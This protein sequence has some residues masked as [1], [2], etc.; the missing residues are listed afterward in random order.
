[1]AAAGPSRRVEL[2][3]GVGV[4][5]AGAVL[6]YAMLLA[7]GIGVRDELMLAAPDAARPGETLA[8]RAYLYHDPENPEGP[9]PEEGDVDVELRDRARVLSRATLTSGALM[10]LEGSIAVPED[11][12]GALYLVARARDDGH[13]VATVARPLEVADD[14]APAGE[15]DRAA[16]PLAHFSLGT[17]TQE[18]VPAALATAVEMGLLVPLP[19][20]VDTLDAWV[21]GGVCVPDARCLLAVDVGV[22]DV[23][24]QLTNCAGVEVLPPLPV[25]GVAT[26]YHVLPLVVHG[27]EGTCDIAAV[28]V[29]EGSRGT[30]VAHRSIRFPVAL[31]TPFFGVE[32]AMVDGSPR[33][34]AIAP[35]GRDGIVLDVFHDGRWRNTMTLPAANEPSAALDYHE[36]PGD[37]LPAGVYLFQARSDALPTAYVAPRLV[38]VGGDAALAAAHEPPARAGARGPE[39]TFFLAAHEQRGFVLPTATSGLIEDRARLD[40]RKRAA[41]TIA[42]VGMAVGIILLV[43]T[44]LR[45]GLSAD[46]QARAVMAAAGVP[47]ADDASARRRGRLNVVLMV[48]ALGLALATGA[49]LIAAHEL[50]I[51]SSA[52]PS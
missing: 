43:V 4:C 8:L 12:H 27:P 48:L 15:A 38:V 16:S 41:R 23:E 25:T 11:A 32:T 24:P 1:M 21:V 42:F 10:S 6:V 49:A 22:T 26:R 20:H 39:L 2:A 14:A 30:T 46:A 18:P 44:V 34:A 7:E 37:P 29:A 40:G 9:T 13:V 3:V 51:D 33:Y 31:A 19:P 17:L 35:P 50:A 36:L 52:T 45:R 5:V 28:S 47:G